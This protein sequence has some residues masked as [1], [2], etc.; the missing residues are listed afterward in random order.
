VSLAVTRRC[1][2]RCFACC[3]AQ[4][5][6][7]SGLDRPLADWLT[8]IDA[9]ARWLPRPR[10]I[11]LT[12]G[13]PL[14]YQGVD[15]LIARIAAHGYTPAVNTNGVLLTP[16]RARRMRAAGLQIL[17]IS[18]DGLDATHDRLRNAPGSFQG[19]MD[20]LDWLSREGEL[21]V[22]VVSIVNAQNAAELPALARR[23]TTIAAV[24]AIRF[25]AISPTLS[26]PWNE[27]FFAKDPLWPRSPAELDRV[28][29]A[30]DGIER[31]AAG[32]LPI[33]NGPAQF[34]AWR[35]YFRDPLGAFA[36]AGC[37]LESEQLLATPD[38]LVT[39]C[40]EC[41]V[42]GDIAADPAGLW[43]S[44]AAETLRN[45]MRACH[46]ACNLRLNCHHQPT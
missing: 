37:P 30:I 40:D 44:R 15:D 1:N 10:R 14:L 45:R 35:R 36:G 34:A 5:A 13:E 19:V 38:G 28:L 22:Q 42:L 29:A 16:E 23:L 8:F 11:V 46:R 27:R 4:S 43:A 26:R 31:L 17:N 25:Q 12:G 33:A 20:M 24:A 7:E 32:G 18:L 6:A 2:L 3:S 41:G 9:L 39:M 21:R